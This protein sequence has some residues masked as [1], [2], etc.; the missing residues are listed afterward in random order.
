MPAEA[1]EV[2]RQ[3]YEAFSRSDFGWMIQN[4]TPDVVIVQPPERPSAKTYRGRTEFR[5]AFTEW[6]SQWDEFD[7][8]LVDLVELNDHQVLG[9]CRQHMRR[10]DLD[11]DQERF[12]LFTL[13]D[14]KVARLELFHS[15]DAARAAADGGD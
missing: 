10:G 15:L 11:V 6:P 3:G 12:D 13:R 14:G 5:A 9:S 2:V 1:L 4:C 8:E 7:L